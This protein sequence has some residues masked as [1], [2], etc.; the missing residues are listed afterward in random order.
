MFTDKRKAE[1]T[2]CLSRYYVEERLIPSI[3]STGLR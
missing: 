1:N 2:S 3:S